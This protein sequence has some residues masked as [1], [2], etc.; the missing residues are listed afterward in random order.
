MLRNASRTGSVNSGGTNLDLQATGQGLANQGW[1]QYIQNLQPFLGG[2]SSA[3][4]GIAGV[5]T[6]LGQGINQSFGNQAGLGWQTQTGIGN[7]TANADL[8]KNAAGANVLGLGMNLAKLGVSGGGSFLGGGLGNALTGGG[9]GAG[10][11]GGTMGGSLF[12]P[13]MGQAGPGGSIWGA[14]P[15]GTIAPTFFADGGRPPVGEPSIVGE[16]GPEMFVPD[17]P[18]T[19]IPN[20]AMTSVRG[21]QSFAERLQDWLHDHGLPASLDPQDMRANPVGAAAIANSA[22]GGRTEPN[23]RVNQGFRAINERTMP[24]VVA[25]M[26]EFL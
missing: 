21:P 14:A 22:F 19:V 18:G 23:V 13:Q 2:A 24:P 11:G 6:G 7:A 9:G 17:Q 3:A 1:Q 8:A 20:E 4:S 15:G 26:A 16:G 25:R 12:G 10:G 5:D